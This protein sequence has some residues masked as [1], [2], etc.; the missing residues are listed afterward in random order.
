M[1]PWSNN[2]QKHVGWHVVSM[3]YMY[4][5]SVQFKTMELKYPEVTYLLNSG[6]DYMF[7]L[8]RY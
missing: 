4:V 5:I 7:W 3:Q 6:L 8:H 2:P 1:H